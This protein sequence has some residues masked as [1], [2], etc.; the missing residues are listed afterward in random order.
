MRGD[1]VAAKRS[2]HLGGTLWLPR[3]ACIWGSPCEAVDIPMVPCRSPYD[4][5]TERLRA[6][7]SWRTKESFV[8]GSRL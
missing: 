1:P 7:G 5:G 3:G 8:V 2:L 4:V 6:A